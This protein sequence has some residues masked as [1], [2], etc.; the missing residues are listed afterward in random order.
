MI[1]L[2][3]LLVT[4]G[5][6]VVLAASGAAAQETSPQAFLDAIYKPYLAKDFKGTEY[7]KPAVLRR[8]FVPALANAIIKDMAAAAKRKEVPMLNGDPFLDAQDWEI[9]D[10]RIEVKDS[11]TTR[12]TGTVTFRNAGDP[13]RVALDL[14]KTSAGW[15][16]AEIKAPS[17]SLRALFKLK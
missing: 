9:A 1:A 17:G 2:S 6:A 5:L 15:R 3:R 13:R 12:A 11:G 7:Y 8:L 14:V 10:L 4:F 16:I